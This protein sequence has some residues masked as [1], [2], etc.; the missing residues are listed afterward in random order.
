MYNETSLNYQIFHNRIIY[1][2]SGMIH[3]DSRSISC[4][5]SSDVAVKPSD[6]PVRWLWKAEAPADAPTRLLVKAQ[7]QL[8]RRTGFP[9]SG[10]EAAGHQ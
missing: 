10:A 7:E 3:L 5:S 8:S 9:K 6:V 4:I 1:Y 2:T